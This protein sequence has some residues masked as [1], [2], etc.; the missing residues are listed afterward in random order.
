MKKYSLKNIIIVTL[1]A[2]A[3]LAL[4][5]SNAYCTTYEQFRKMYTEEKFQKILEEEQQIF[6]EKQQRRRELIKNFLLEKLEERPYSVQEI[7]LWKIPKELGLD[8]ASLVNIIFH[9]LVYG[10]FEG[11]ERIVERVDE[12][13][14]YYCG[15]AKRLG[16]G[17][18]Y[19]QFSKMYTR[20]E[21]QVI[22]K[23]RLEKGKAAIMS[24]WLEKLR[25]KPLTI[26][27]LLLEIP[28]DLIWVQAKLGIGGAKVGIE[29]IINGY[30][31]IVRRYDES[32]KLYYGLREQIID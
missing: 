29:S 26:E 31:G 15:L 1:L 9:N 32:R 3:S 5:T 12:K 23:E 16:E 7:L 10:V 11:E 28:K 4:T 13:D 8:T 14:V 6:E 18:T 30:K 22:E 25:K 24:I 21:Y 20:E 17:G 27:E 19:E 2:G